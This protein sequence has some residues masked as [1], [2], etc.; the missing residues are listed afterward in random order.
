M[1]NVFVDDE[2]Y[3]TAFA[4][5]CLKGAG[6]NSLK[7]QRPNAEILANRFPHLGKM[8]F[9]CH[10]TLVWHYFLTAREIIR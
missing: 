5:N 3:F 9:I 10:R 6:R 8:P 7:F 2:S 4:A 1:S